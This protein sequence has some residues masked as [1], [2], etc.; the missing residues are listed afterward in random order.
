MT[1]EEM[2]SIDH[3]FVNF[4]YKKDEILQLLTLNKEA[5]QKEILNNVEKP[6]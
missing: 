2:R 5:I 4:Y 3:Y 1:R 6:K